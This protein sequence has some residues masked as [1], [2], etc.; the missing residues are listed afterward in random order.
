MQKHWVLTGVFC[1]ALAAHPAMAQYTS[2]PTPAPAA[3]YLETR[4]TD[5]ETQLRSL[6][7]R[8]EEQEYE[9]K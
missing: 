8:L 2:S 3:T 9:N 1:A 6:N 7:G 4:V 5:L